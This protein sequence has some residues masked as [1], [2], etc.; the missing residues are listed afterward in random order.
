MRAALLS[1]QLL[2][3]SIMRISFFTLP[4]YS[5]VRTIERLDHLPVDVDFHSLPKPPSGIRRR[6]NYPFGRHFRGIVN[7]RGE[8]KCRTK[9]WFVGIFPD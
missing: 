1:Q 8:M 4:C 6:Q 7:A 9:C 2:R 3:A 5:S